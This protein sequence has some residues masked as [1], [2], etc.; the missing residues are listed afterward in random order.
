VSEALVA[1]GTG[2]VLALVQ[3]LRERRDRDLRQKGE[4]RTREADL[5]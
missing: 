1:L 4:R 5:S 3:L 2:V